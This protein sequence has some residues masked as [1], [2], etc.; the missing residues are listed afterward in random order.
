MWEILKRARR[1]LVWQLAV[2]GGLVLAVAA[3]E[4]VPN[5]PTRQVSGATEIQL[6]PGRNCWNNVCLNYDPQR[7]RVGV[8]GRE[9]VSVPGS[10]DTSDGFVTVAEFN[11]IMHAARSATP[12]GSNR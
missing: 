11:R 4:P 10:V 12:L 3:C 1:P 2:P 8:R 6:V 7:D 5:N 9:Y